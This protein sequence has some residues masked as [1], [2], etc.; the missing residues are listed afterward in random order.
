MVQEI[1]IVVGSGIFIAA[2][3]YQRNKN[4]LLMDQGVLVTATIYK[5]VLKPSKKGKGHYHPVVRFL[6]EDNVWVTEELS[7][8]YSPALE[9]GTQLDVIYNP[10]DTSEIVINRKLELEL[11][12]L[13]FIGAGLLGLAW[14][15]LQYLG[16]V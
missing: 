6:T 14:S 13:F 9:E 5:N 3:L 8:G 15:V 7:T 16:V 11:V 1:I 4:N 2:G 12:P 10:E